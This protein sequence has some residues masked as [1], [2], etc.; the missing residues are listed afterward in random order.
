MD[1]RWHGRGVLA[2]YVALLDNAGRQFID[3]CFPVL[4]TCLLAKQFIKG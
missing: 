1:Y 4:W 2:K 3:R